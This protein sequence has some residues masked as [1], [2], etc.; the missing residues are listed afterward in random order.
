MTGIS[1]RSRAGSVA[2]AF[3]AVVLAVGVVT[4]AK[5]GARPGTHASSELNVEDLIMILQDWASWPSTS[6]CERAA[7]GRFRA[8]CAP[9]CDGMEWNAADAGLAFAA[10]TLAQEAARFIITRGEV[11]ASYA[12]DIWLGTY[13]PADG[14]VTVLPAQGYDGDPTVD[15]LVGAL[16]D[17]HNQAWAPLPLP[18][19]SDEPL[20][21]IDDFGTLRVKPIPLTP[22][23]W[24]GPYYRLKY[25]LLPDRPE[26]RVTSRGVDGDVT[27]TV[28]ADF[29]IEKKIEYALI[30][31]SRI[32]IGKNVRVEGVLGTRYGIVE[33]ELENADGDPLVM[34]SDFYWL[35]AGLDADLDIFFTQ[36][37]AHDADGDGRLRVY[38]PGES[39]GIAAA[40]GVLI[41][42]D[43]NGY[44]DG[45]D[46]FLGH[47]DTDGDGWVVYDQ[48]LANDAG[49]GLP[50]LEFDDI[51]NQMARL[52]DEARPDR[53]GDGL[54]TGSDTALGYRD[55]ILD[56]K[57]QYAKVRG[58]L[59]FAVSRNA[60]EFAHGES[61]QTVVHGPIVPA[62]G[63]T[64]VIFE[65]GD[66]QLRELTTDMFQ[67]AGTWFEAQV[68][69]G[70]ADFD[71]QVSAGEAGG[72]TFTPPGP[73]TWE[74]I[75]Y[76][77]PGAYDY[78]Q[79]PIYEDMRFENV[80]IP[81]GTN[82]LFKNCT[83]VGVTFIE[84]T[85]DCYH[86][87][88]NYAGAIEKVEDPHNPGN[89]IYE[90]KYPGVTAEFGDGTPVPDTKP[91]SNNIRFEGCTFVGS[92]A[93]DT[94]GEFTHWRNH[95]QFTG[96]TRFY[97]DADDPD[98][99]NEE[100]LVRDAIVAEI[101]AMDETTRGELRKS[102][103]LLPGWW[104]AVGSFA[105]EQAAD[106]EDT[107]KTKLKGTIVA[108]ILEVRGTVDVRG[109]VLITFR[110]VADAGPLFYGGHT[111]AFKTAIGYFASDEDVIPG[112]PEFP[113]FGEIILRDDPEARLPDGIPWAIRVQRFV[114]RSPSTPSLATSCD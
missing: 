112:D 32:T 114:R 26:V 104:A 45:F 71:A 107:P 53:D 72:G 109:T 50:P 93:G 86:E 59:V 21:H 97:V 44:V 30:S 66:R 91:F 34:R 108:G 4:T 101:T 110:P 77:A 87:N 13:D 47:F 6:S 78:Y 43:Q 15:S 106:P 85:T 16:L 84:T 1:S 68:P 51:D 14:D 17:A 38:H 60:W 65:A 79:R 7:N 83:F 113:G 95:V 24:N 49:H 76:G 74:P 67:T 41:D 73:A 2:A 48:L 5:G 111:S 28:Q 12:Q 63:R 98:L 11:D 54:V 69:T 10:Q 89:Y 33:G 31:P 23:G 36:L 3:A 105:N 100:P 39:Q 81:M 55:G 37:A 19:P 35:D 96:E 57:D 70:S 64:P 20:P 103:I 8:F 92:V 52:I 29:R 82:G 62:P 27:H 9:G 25:E 22:T 90:P 42:R 18:C 88:W 46:L 56:V 75:P 80:R 58:C 94:P 99:A 61:Y 102:P 40:P